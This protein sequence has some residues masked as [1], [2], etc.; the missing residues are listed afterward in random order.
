MALSRIKFNSIAS[1]TGAYQLVYNPTWMEWPQERNIVKVKML[2]SETANQL[3]YWDGREITMGWDNFAPQ[4]TS[5]VTQITTLRGYID[6]K[7]YVNLGTI[8]NLVLTEAGWIG[9]FRVV[10]CSANIIKDASRWES[11]KLVLVRT[12]A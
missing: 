1:D 6:S 8:T 10:D 11:V 4:H 2:D 5:F 3:I 7:K 9:P 12:I